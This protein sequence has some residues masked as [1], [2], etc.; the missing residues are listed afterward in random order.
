MEV[1]FWTLMKFIL[2]FFLFTKSSNLWNSIMYYKR[3]FLIWNSD[4]Y[5]IR[6]PVFEIWKTL[7]FKNPSVSSSVSV[8]SKRG[9][10]ILVT[11]ELPPHT[12][13]FSNPL[14][15]RSIR[16]SLKFSWETPI[17]FEAKICDGG[18][19]SANHDPKNAIFHSAKTQT[20]NELFLGIQGT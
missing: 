20:Q 5:I 12:F 2:D 18:S 8:T 17:K 4:S 14:K 10:V 19:E 13:W 1:D 3:C 16:K 11:K 9:N 15:L 6:D 7:A